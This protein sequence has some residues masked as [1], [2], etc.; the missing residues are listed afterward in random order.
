MGR[1]YDDAGSAS[2]MARAIL[3]YMFTI[4]RTS[5]F[6]TD[7]PERICQAYVSEEHPLDRDGFCV[8]YS[9]EFPDQTRCG[10]VHK[11]PVACRIDSRVQ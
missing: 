1:W 2:T 11:E 10:S 5:A 3:L 9:I 6:V 8:G 4:E 7:F